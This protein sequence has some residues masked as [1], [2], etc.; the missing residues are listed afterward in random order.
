VAKL[1]DRFSE[2]NL[3]YICPGA[4]TGFLRGKGYIDRAYERIVA[5]D[6]ESLKE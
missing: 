5:L 4:N 2:D 1:R 6:L 3:K